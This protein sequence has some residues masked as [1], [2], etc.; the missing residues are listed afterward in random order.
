M[1]CC[2]KITLLPRL[3]P[4]SIG[5]A[6]V[7]AACFEVPSKT[8]RVRWPKRKREKLYRESEPVVIRKGFKIVLTLEVTGMEMCGLGLP[9]LH[10]FETFSNNAL[11]S[12]TDIKVSEL[13]ML[14]QYIGNSALVSDGIWRKPRNTVSYCEFRFVIIS[15]G[16]YQNV[17]E[18]RSRL[19]LGNDCYHFF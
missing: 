12:S 10:S 2:V 8:S 1:A 17:S 5:Y 19:N 3:F 11:I 4:F 13:H 6:N 9:R 14:I 15:I 16:F 18:N 7:I